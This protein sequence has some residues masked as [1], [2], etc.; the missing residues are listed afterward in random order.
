MVFKLKKKFSTLPIWFQ[1]YLIILSIVFGFVLFIF[2][3]IFLTTFCFCSGHWVWGLLMTFFVILPSITFS[4][5]WINK[6]D[7]WW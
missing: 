4:A 6:H 2:L 3:P 1:Y 5:V 7:G